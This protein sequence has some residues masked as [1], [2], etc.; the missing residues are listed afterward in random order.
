M[1][2]L[3]EIMTY[4]DDDIQ[5]KYTNFVNELTDDTYYLFK[6]K[7]MIE[8]VIKFNIALLLLDEEPN[9]DSV[10]THILYN[11]LLMTE[12]YSAMADKGH[13]KI[14]SDIV[15]LTKQSISKKS[16][17]YEMNQILSFKNK[18]E[19]LFTPIDYLIS[20]GYISNTIDKTIE[21][22][23]DDGENNER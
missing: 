7:E 22:F 5:N 8:A 23:L 17:C 11:D 6:D 1:L 18:K 4:F 15:V 10:E 21:A 14:L 20:N 9:K 16:K 19:L 13:Y 2:A 3:S 12:F